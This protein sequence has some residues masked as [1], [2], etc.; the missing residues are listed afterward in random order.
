[1]VTEK[2]PH[3]KKVVVRLMEMPNDERTRM[4]YES[5][6]NMECD[7]QARELEASNN[8]ACTIAKNMLDDGEPISKILK[9]TGLTYKEIE[10]LRGSL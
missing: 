1:M 3:T 2:D 6:R 5:Y 10:N 4:F 7:N 9:Y 8:R